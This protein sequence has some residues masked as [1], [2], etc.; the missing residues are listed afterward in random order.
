MQTTKSITKLY[1]ALFSDKAIDGFKQK[2]LMDI[3]LFSRIKLQNQ[4][5]YI[6]FEGVRII[7]TKVSR[8]G[9]REHLV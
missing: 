4:K 1:S 7:F 2:I 5:F 3:N 6:I 8:K 9:E